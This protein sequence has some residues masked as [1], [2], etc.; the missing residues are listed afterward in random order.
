MKCVDK[1]KCLHLLYWRVVLLR[2]GTLPTKF[3]PATNT[4]KFLSQSSPQQ[5]YFFLNCGFHSDVQMVSII[6]HNKCIMSNWINQSKAIAEGIIITT[7]IKW[8]CDVAH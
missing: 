7:A 8:K 1:N 2:E 3:L 4:E 5:S 6:L